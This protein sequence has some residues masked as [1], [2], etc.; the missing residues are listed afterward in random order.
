MLPSHVIRPRAS[1]VSEGD[2]VSRTI[3]DNG[4]LQIFSMTVDVTVLH[5]NS[6]SDAAYPI[7]RLDTAA[8]LAV[9]FWSAVGTGCCFSMAMLAAAGLIVVC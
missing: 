6:S 2:D 7:C 5:G 8:L 1:S 4:S 9:P 3:R